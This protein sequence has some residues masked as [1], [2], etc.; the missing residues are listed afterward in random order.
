MKNARK[1]LAA[2]LALL[3]A[4]T[5][6]C[7]L[8]ITA[9]AGYKVGD[10]FTFG[11]YPQTRITNTTL[12][13]TLNDKASSWKSLD[14]YSGTGSYNSAFADG[15]GKYCDVTYNNVKYRGV[16]FTAYRPS[17][18]IEPNSTATAPGSGYYQYAN[19]YRINKTYW[20]KYEPLKWTV[21]DPAKGL[22][23]CQSI[24]DS[25][26]IT[27]YVDK[28]NGKYY[29][30]NN[31]TQYY[32]CDYAR[33]SLRTWLNGTFLN[34]TFT[35]AEKN[36]IPATS[37]QNKGYYTL[38]GNNKHTDLDTISTSDKIFLLGYDDL[39][40]T[41]YGFKQLP[42]DPD[43][44]RTRTPTDYAKCMGV[45][46]L[47]NGNAYWRLRSA[48]QNS[49][50]NCVVNHQGVSAWM[51]VV[52]SSSNF[53]GLCPAICCSDV[54]P[55]EVK[56]YTV[57]VKADGYG[58]VSGGGTCKEGSIATVKAT[59][60]LFS[61]FDGWYEGNTKVSSNA[62]YSFFVTKNVTLTAKFSIPKVTLTLKTDGNGTVSGGG[63][64][65]LTTSVTI[66]ATPNSG[67]HF[68]GWY[69]GSTL[70]SS[71]ATYSFQ[72]MN[73]LTLTAKFEKDSSETPGTPDPQPESVCP[74]CGGQHIGFFQGII[75]WF[76]S[77]LAS[78]F[79]ARY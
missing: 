58:S 39:I 52:S 79:G 41:S 18:T 7:C 69:N 66:K 37:L 48:G 55:D 31:S 53:I 47:D 17:D 56:Y 15:T 75:G 78:I 77:I 34:A 54:K 20:F 16:K 57:T 22:V 1:L 43:A 28:Q 46:T 51:N 44:K 61:T 64:Y 9:S 29:N 68:V 11:S 6:F 62:E 65:D 33:S 13:S 40:N 71:Q 36:K 24:I 32:A 60:N 21:L 74:W 42:G 38:T 50:D 19:G 23:V 12:I 27:N 5:V 3:M 72:L 35:S 63:T 4:A 73:D 45:R 59:P 10:T 2:L 26:P 30:A 14:W 67:Y 49:H 25:R 76:H 70:Y 8:P